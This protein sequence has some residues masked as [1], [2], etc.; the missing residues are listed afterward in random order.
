MN[1][2]EEYTCTDDLRTRLLFS[3]LGTSFF[4]LIVAY[5]PALN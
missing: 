4:L 3:W 5:F 1:S 2:V